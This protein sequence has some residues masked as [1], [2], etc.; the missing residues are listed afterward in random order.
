MGSVATWVLSIRDQGIYP[1]RATLAAGCGAETGISLLPGSIRWRLLLSLPPKAVAS[2]SSGRPGRRR[3]HLPSLFEP[4]VDL[5]LA[6]REDA[7][8][9]VVSLTRFQNRLTVRF[10]FG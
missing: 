3:E 5:G 10:H 4:L 6:A 1:V 2:L 9:D 7:A 8:D